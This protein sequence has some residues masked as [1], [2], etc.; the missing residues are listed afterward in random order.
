MNHEDLASSP[1]AAVCFGV[2][3]FAL[4]G[5]AAS[6]DVHAKSRDAERD[7]LVRPVAACVSGAAIVPC[8]DF[9]EDGLSD[10]EEAV[11]GTDPQDA[12]SDDDGL[13]DGFEVFGLGASPVDARD[14]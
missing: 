4:L 10:V 14:R 1:R 7:L 6:A 2:L 8:E 11:F 3:A 12:D 9:D 13:D 5:A